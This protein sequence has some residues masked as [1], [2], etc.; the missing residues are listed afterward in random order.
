MHASITNPA[1]RP[2]PVRTIECIYQLSARISNAKIENPDERFA[3]ARCQ[4]L[5]W[6]GNRMRKEVGKS[7][8]RAAFDGGAFE[9]SQHGQLYA[10]TSVDDLD[11]WAAT[12]EHPDSDVPTR[13]WA[14]DLALRQVDSEVHFTIRLM[15][16]TSVKVVSVPRRS[17]P[18]IVFDLAERLGL[19]DMLPVN[20]KPLAVESDADL[21]LLQVAISD[22]QRRLPVVL[23][24]ETDPAARKDLNVAEFV[25]D[26]TFLAKELKGLALVAYMSRAA[27]Y[28]WTKRVGKAWSCY[29]G[30]IRTYRPGVD[31]GIDTP[32]RHPAAMADEITY[33]RHEDPV[34]QQTTYGEKAFIR[35]LKEKMFY[36]LASRS[37]RMEDYLF[38][39]H[40]RSLN[41]QQQLSNADGIV[42][43]K[44]YHNE[45]VQKLQEELA[46]VYGENSKQDQQIEELRQR[47]FYLNSR[48]DQYRRQLQVAG[49][50]DAEIPIPSA[51]DELDA[52]QHHLEGQ[53]VIAAKAIREAEKSQYEDPKLVYQALL[54]LGNEYREM[55]LSGGEHKDRFG[56]RL[57]Q[58]GLTISGSIT[59]SRAG[60]QG[61]EYRANHPTIPS[62]RIFLDEHLRK[63]NDH[64][65]RRC[66]RIYFTW[67]PQEKLV[68]VGWLPSHLT[69][70]AS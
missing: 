39:R 18:R 31:F 38:Y 11:L 70:R 53:V 56:A 58:L 25:I 33:W 8:P 47:T 29:N 35:F 9:I 4:C 6:L 13:A 27:G 67:D 16:S 7:F 28:S 26:P 69:T 43:L 42:E 10:A 22:A 55:R 37:L 12:M 48:L 36:T 3:E 52:W 68:I 41:I 17:I 57:K 1:T 54:L 61:E 15:C 63:G 34:D 24:S 44:S 14:T 20:N 59:K 51:L 62:K 30:A 49:T 40:A 21:D 45:E 50:A 65:Q 5:M 2:S 64:D 23:V 19:D 66:L 60:E 32:V 46:F